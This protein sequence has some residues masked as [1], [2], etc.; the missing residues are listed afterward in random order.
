M[1]IA[2]Q[3]FDSTIVA[4]QSLRPHVAGD[5]L[6]AL[7]ACESLSCGN[8]QSSVLIVACACFPM[9]LWGAA[10]PYYFNN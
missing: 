3:H 4:Q 1:D 7:V 8:Y 6:G 9:S 10:R 2:T 5:S